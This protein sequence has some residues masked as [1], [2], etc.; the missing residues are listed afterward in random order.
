MSI[1]LN[2]YFGDIKKRHIATFIVILPFLIIIG[3]CG[4]Q[5]YRQAKDLLGVVGDSGTVAISDNYQIN[6]NRYVLRDT[7]TDVQKEYFNELKDLMENNT[8]TGE[9]I[10]GSIVKNFVADFY[11]FSNKLGQY[12]VG[13]MYYVFAPQRQ[14][15]YIQARDQFYKY[16]NNYINQ[17]GAEALLEVENV[18]VDVTNAPSD[19]LYSVMMT[20]E[21]TGEEYE[22]QH[23]YYLVEA[24]WTYVTKEGGMSTSSYDTKGNFVVI[25]R[26]G[27]KYEIVYVGKEGYKQSEE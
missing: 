21:E 5:I 4:Y 26:D 22:E 9:D 12:D 7:A 25:N 24:R 15:I 8:G 6:N 1:L 17:Y 18:E 2:K 3:I 19:S 10:A 23:N 27:D 20:D 14:T 13:G 16:I 11:T